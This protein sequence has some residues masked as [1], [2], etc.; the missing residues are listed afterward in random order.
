MPRSG[1]FSVGG[2]G[3][4]VKRKGERQVPLRIRIG[5]TAPEKL[6]NALDAVLQ[7][8]AMDKQLIRGDRLL[9]TV[10]YKTF[11]CAEV[12]GLIPFVCQLKRAAPDAA[13]RAYPFGCATLPSGSA[14]RCLRRK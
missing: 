8:V 14:R 1:A 6:F 2:T 5:E 3:F 10:F 11:E 4:I 7:A 9:K 12:V 13:M